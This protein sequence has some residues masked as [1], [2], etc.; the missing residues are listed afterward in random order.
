MI[1][2]LWFYGTL[3]FSSA[4]FASLTLLAA[5]FGVRPRA[6]GVYDWCT[7]GWSRL[8]LRGA[9]TPV[10]VEGL[11]R[12]PDEPVVYA[13]NH[14]SMF[15]IWALAAVLPGST[16]FVA[17]RELARIPLLGAAMIR[18][19]H[20][21]IDRQV[22]TRALEAYAQAAAQIRRGISPIVFPEGTRSLTGELL[23]FKN[24]PFG[25]AIAAHAP[26]VPIYVHQT[27]RI[28]PKG[29][30]I[31]RPRPIRVTVGDP[32][33]TA[34]LGPDDRQA[35]RD[36]VHDAIAELRARVDSVTTLS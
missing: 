5:L 17:K 1:R 10:R 4:F 20:V 31:M 28:L 15:D 19:G 30:R 16:R 24:A 26:V 14:S 35:L 7:V 36:R 11:E 33:P 27:F 21:M 2:T 13:S 6:G 12:V 9:G 23:P 25:L 8:I 22:K 32:V 3:F 18:A 29:A 34:G